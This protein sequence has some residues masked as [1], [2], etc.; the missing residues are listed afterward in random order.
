MLYS[1]IILTLLQLTLFS[2]SAESYSFNPRAMSSQFNNTK[3]PNDPVSCN[4]PG[5]NSASGSD[6][7]AANAILSENPDSSWNP[8]PGCTAIVCGYFGASIIV[9]DSG[10]R[11]SEGNISFESIEQQIWSIQQKCGDNSGKAEYSGTATWNDSWG[12]NYKGLTVAV[13]GVEIC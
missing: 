12:A 10:M 5:W 7:D 4:P 2:N 1:P 9:C 3:L 6:I 8:T 11:T 13:M